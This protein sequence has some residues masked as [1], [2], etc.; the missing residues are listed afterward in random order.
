[1]TVSCPRDGGRPVV[2][3]IERGIHHDAFR[4]VSSVVA[5]VERQVRCLVTQPITEMR[6]A[7]AQCAADLLRVG[8]EQ[9]LIGVE[10]VSRL[11]RV[12]AMHPVAVELAGLQVRKIGVPNQIGA[13][14]KRDDID[15]LAAR[16][17][18]Q[19][20]ID[21]LGMLGEERKVDTF[22]VPHGTQRVGLSWPDGAS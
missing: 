7:P 13:L 15:L 12:G 22:A 10:S 5:A 1:M 2:S 9:Q 3:P 4:H 17:I 21:L 16:G 19:A 18:E 11:G 8:V 20:Q 14:G 6:V